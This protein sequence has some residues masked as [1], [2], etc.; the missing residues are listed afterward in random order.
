M[1]EKQYF[2]EEKMVTLTESELQSMLN[3]ARVSANESLMREKKD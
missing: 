2:G 1:I 3:E